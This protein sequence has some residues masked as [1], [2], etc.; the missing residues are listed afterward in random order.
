MSESA[1]GSWRHVEHARSRRDQRSLSLTG[2]NG[3]AADKLA[4]RGQHDLLLR[5]MAATLIIAGLVMMKVSSGS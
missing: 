4:E 3:G 1:G 5:V 2:S